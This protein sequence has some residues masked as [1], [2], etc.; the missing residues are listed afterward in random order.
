[1]YRL[2]RRWRTPCSLPLKS[3]LFPFA[4]QMTPQPAISL[5]AQIR[6]CEPYSSIFWAQPSL[7]SSINPRAL[8]GL[9]GRKQLESRPKHKFF[10]RGGTTSL[11]ITIVRH[12][13][14]MLRWRLRN[15][16]TNWLPKW[17]D[18]ADYVLD[19]NFMKI[20]SATL[21]FNKLLQGSLGV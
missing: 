14:I 20:R 16:C 17:F 7:I 12:K 21:R 13:P 15:Y 19:I 11:L 18:D 9:L 8:L 4:S 2:P 3:G 5:T 1:M 6:P 10:F